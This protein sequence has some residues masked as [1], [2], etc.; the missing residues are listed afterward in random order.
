MNK[1][2]FIVLV[3]IWYCGY[4]YYLFC[5]TGKIKTWIQ[6]YS[7]VAEYVVFS[8]VVYSGKQIQMSINHNY[9]KN[10]KMH[11]KSWEKLWLSEF[12][13]NFKSEYC[14]ANLKHQHDINHKS[15]KQLYMIHDLCVCDRSRVQWISECLQNWYFMILLNTP[16]STDD[17][18]QNLH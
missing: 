13:C 16:W 4:N 3:F 18:Q 5:F 14:V 10:I 6:K 11:I 1:P 2:C 9:H 15:I 8:V 17:Y 7:Y 12:I